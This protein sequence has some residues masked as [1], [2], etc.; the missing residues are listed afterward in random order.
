M[1]Y[2]K[3]TGLNEGV[4]IEPFGCTLDDLDEALVE[5]GDM[6]RHYEKITKDEYDALSLNPAIEF[7]KLVAQLAKMRW[8]FEVVRC[9]MSHVQDLIKVIPSLKHH[10]G[11]DIRLLICPINNTEYLLYEFDT[12][13]IVAALK[14]LENW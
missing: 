5:S 14:D 11:K 12:D 4:P 10:I 9:D 13:G 8:E 3:I 1:K 6:S 7:N 2:Y